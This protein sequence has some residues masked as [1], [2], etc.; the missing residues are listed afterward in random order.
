MNAESVQRLHLV[1]SQRLHQ[2]GPAFDLSLLNH[3][4]CAQQYNPALEIGPSAPPPNAHQCCPSFEF[5]SSAPS[6]YTH[7]YNPTLD[8]GPFSFIVQ[9]QQYDSPVDYDLPEDFKNPH[10]YNPTAETDARAAFQNSQHQGTGLDPALFE[11]CQTTLQYN[12][13]VTPTS[14]QSAE[15]SWQ[16]SAL[17]QSA[18]QGFQNSPQNHPAAFKRLAT[19]HREARVLSQS[20]EAASSSLTSFQTQRQGYSSGAGSSVGSLQSLTEPIGTEAEPMQAIEESECSVDAAERN[21]WHMAMNKHGVY[22]PNGEIRFSEDGT[23]QWR[24]KEGAR[25]CKYSQSSRK[26]HNSL[27]R[28]NAVKHE[29]IRGQLLAECAQLGEYSRNSRSWLCPRS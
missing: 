15:C 8:S 20:F 29:D 21:V 4:P 19:H 22:R 3:L 23:M 2:C 25:W 16:N 5:G 26:I 10:Q 9:P 27:V 6:P 24:E 28:G 13:L 14:P 7:Q 18:L 1:S 17:F 12:P 11:R